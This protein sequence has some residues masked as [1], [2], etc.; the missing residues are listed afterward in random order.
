MEIS[1]AAFSYGSLKVTWGDMQDSATNGS[2]DRKKVDE[3]KDLVRRSGGDTYVC[4]YQL[5]VPHFLN[6]LSRVDSKCSTQTCDRSIMS[7]K[8]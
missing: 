7:S 4:E 5:W 1:V 8:A 6:Q 2:D 3:I